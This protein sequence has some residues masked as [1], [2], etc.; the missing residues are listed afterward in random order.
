M[1]TPI[2][3]SVPVVIDP[4]QMLNLC[5]VE[6]NYL[7]CWA[8]FFRETN[9]LIV[10]KTQLSFL[11][12]SKKADFLHSFFSVSYL[13]HL[14]CNDIRHGKCS[15]TELSLD[16]IPLSHFIQHIFSLGIVKVIVP[17]SMDHN[18]PIL[19]HMLSFPL[20]TLLEPFSAMNMLDISYRS[21]ITNILILFHC[22]RYLEYYG[23]RNHVVL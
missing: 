12:L 16:V 9:K 4:V 19:N 8:L 17:Y 7:R 10:Y 23:Y 20:V 5:K 21:S 15:T 22:C 13:L 11:M 3:L 6:H 18:T 1:Y 14:M 2:T